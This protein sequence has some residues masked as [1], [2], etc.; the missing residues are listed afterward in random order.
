MMCKN[1][2]SKKGIAVQLDGW[3]SVGD[4]AKLCSGDTCR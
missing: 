4:K 3:I 1:M 2:S